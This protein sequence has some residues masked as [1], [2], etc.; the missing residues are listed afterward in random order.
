MQG[1]IKGEQERITILAHQVEWMARERV[2]RSPAHYLTTEKQ[3]AEQG[4]A[5]VLAL[6]KRLAERK[7]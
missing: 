5:K 3:H 2:L 7:E 4:A 1:R 6:F